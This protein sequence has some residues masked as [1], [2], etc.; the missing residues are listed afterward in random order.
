MALSSGDKRALIVLG[1]VV[2]VA[3][4][5]WLLFLRGGGETPESTPVAAADRSG[6]TTGTSTLPPPTGTAPPETPSLAPPPTLSIPVLAGRDPFS[7]VISQSPSPGEET[8]PSP[9]TSG[10]GGGGE[11]GG[12]QT[13]DTKTD[14][15]NTVTLLD[16]KNPQGQLQVN[17]KVNED[18]F[19]N[20]EV[21]DTFLEGTYKVFQITDPCATFQYQS[22]AKKKGTGTSGKF[23]L[24]VD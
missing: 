21:G 23:T 5:V 2:G 11:S 10:N 24:C 13:T 16:V 9:A 19:K 15:G 1:G 22:G 20:L 6:A 14:H 7:P 18:N 12:S 8:S 17:V 4:L 3:A